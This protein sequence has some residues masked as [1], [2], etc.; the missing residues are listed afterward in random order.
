MGVNEELGFGGSYKW[1][2][3]VH[4]NMVRCG[5]CEADVTDWAQ[6]IEA[7]THPPSTPKVWSCPECDTVL[8]VSDWG[9][10]RRE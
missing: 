6:R 7:M 4:S 3:A 2:P 9:S 1:R 8:G 10:E 5:F